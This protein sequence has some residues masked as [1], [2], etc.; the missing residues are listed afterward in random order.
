MFPEL[1]D[2]RADQ[3]VFEYANREMSEIDL[4]KEFGV[5]REL[6]AGVVDVKSFYVETADDV[7]E[8]IRAILEYV[9][10]EKLYI[11]PDCGFFQLPRW[12]S[13]LKLQA[14]V[15]GTKIV[16]SELGLEA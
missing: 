15:A 16:R 14:M 11:N 13:Y 4:W 8:R 5:D 12:L 1:L 9:P 10:A 3:L 6:G 2:A 7:A